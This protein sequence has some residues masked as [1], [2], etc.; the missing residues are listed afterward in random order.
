MGERHDG[1]GH[2][3]YGASQTTAAQQV[4]N[5]LNERGLAVRGQA[6]GQ[7][8]G[9]I[10]RSVSL[11]AYPV[12]MEEAR[13]VAQ[14]AVRIAMRDGTGWMATILRKPGAAYA[15]Y[16]D[17]VQLEKVANS[18]RFM[19]KGWITSDGLDV[20]DDFVRYAA[21]LIGD[22]FPQI[23]LEGG[24]QRFARFDITFIGKKCPGYV[25]VRFR[26]A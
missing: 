2:I 1:F 4:V 23:P 17:K 7:L 3:E 5:Y 18:S 8:P 25:P 26:P 24:L 15:P 16:Y 14:E 13:R 9:V 19:H 10:Q 6:T 20:T 21:P 11:Q 22:G 12:D